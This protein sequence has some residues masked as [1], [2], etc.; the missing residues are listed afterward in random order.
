MAT[1]GPN[2][3]DGAPSWSGLVGDPWPEAGA[4]GGCGAFGGG[5]R[6]AINP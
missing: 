4:G 1:L 6:Q 3:D 5:W 2:F